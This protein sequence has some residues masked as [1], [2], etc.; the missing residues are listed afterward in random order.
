MIWIMKCLTLFLQ[1]A[2]LIWFEKF[3]DLAPIFLLYLTDSLTSFLSPIFLLIKIQSMWLLVGL[4]VGKVSYHL[5]ISIVKSSYKALQIYTVE[6]LWKLDTFKKCTLNKY[7]PYTQT[8]DTQWRQK[9]RKS[10]NLGRCGRQNM[11]GL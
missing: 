3:V 1:L 11:L 9:S 2:A 4:L 10:E 6:L 7:L 8:T 5:S